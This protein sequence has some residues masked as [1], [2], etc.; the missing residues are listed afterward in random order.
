[1]NT[2]YKFLTEMDKMWA[3]MLIEILKN[4]SIPS[5]TLPVHGA[6]LTM[7]TGTQERLKIY[8]P[9]ESLAKAEELFGE[10]FPSKE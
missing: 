5:A 10:A 9:A 3:D 7:K 6:G 8:V 2:D 1:M 4:N